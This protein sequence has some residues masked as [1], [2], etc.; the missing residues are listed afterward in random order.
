MIPNSLVLAMPQS[1]LRLTLDTPRWKIVSIALLT[2][3]CVILLAW[4]NR[5]LRRVEPEGRI[6]ALGIRLIRPLALLALVTLLVP[7]V[8]REIN[9]SGE[10]SRL[11]DNGSTILLYLS[12]AWLLWLVARLI[13]E[14]V[15][16]SPRIPDESLDANL[17][18]MVAGLI[19]AVGAIGLVAHCGQTLGLPIVSIVAGLGIGG[20]AIAL[21]IRPTLENLIGGFN[22]YLDKPVRVGDYCTFG[23]QGGTVE[24][25]GIRSTKLRALDQ[26]LISVPNAEFANMQIINWSRNDVLISRVVS[27]RYETDLDQLRYVLATIRE[28]LHAHPKIDSDTIRVR[29]ENFAESSLDICVWVFVRTRDWHDY[30]AVQEDV[31]FRICEIVKSS[32]AEFAFP[33][34][35]LY[36]GRD[37]RP[38]QH[39]SEK[40]RDEVAKWRENHQLPFPRFPSSKL[41]EI[42]NTL[43]YP[44]RGSPEFYE[45]EEGLSRGGERLSVEDSGENGEPLETDAEPPGENHKGEDITPRPRR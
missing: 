29:F 43:N 24:A 37:A 23:D 8:D 19:G 36:I 35:T 10:F 2:V 38:E 11:I 39:R 41:K 6:T 12:S 16:L 40:A 34:Q 32:G 31:L 5:A 22:L 15:I 13:A 7:F 45:T 9:T 18:R 3:I 4:L 25:I 21:A 20:L 33:S 44:P 1:M 42:D 14:S 17:L 28:M 27:L 26:N 30:Y